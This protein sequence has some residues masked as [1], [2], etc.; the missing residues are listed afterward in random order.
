MTR[1]RFASTK[2]GRSKFCG[3][4]IAGSSR[5]CA[6]D[7]PRSGTASAFRSRP[8]LRNAQ[9]VRLTDV[10]ESYDRPAKDVRKCQHRADF[11]RDQMW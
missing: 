1:R 4:D 2:S 10:H 9:T 11:E 8:P 3:V 7:N 5:K 6:N